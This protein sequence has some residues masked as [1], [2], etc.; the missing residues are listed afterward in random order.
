MSR[1]FV[2]ASFV[3]LA[4][5]LAGLFACPALAG[6]ASSGRAIVDCSLASI[7]QDSLS[8][9]DHDF[10]SSPTTTPFASRADR[11]R[12][13]DHHSQPSWPGLRASAGVLAAKAGAGAAVRTT[14]QTHHVI[15]TRIARALEEN[16]NLAGR[17]S[18]RDPRFT[19]QAVDAAAHRGYQTWHRQLDEE[20]VGWLQRNRLSWRFPNGF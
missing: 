16:P 2:R 13:N 7:R 11:I 8:A 17:Y 6:Y 3:P 19:T 10:A 9:Y 14:G 1:G 4:V 5:A 18:A 12:T 20:V 15:S